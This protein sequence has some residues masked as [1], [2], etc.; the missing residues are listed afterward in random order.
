MENKETRGKRK[1]LSGVVVSDKGNKTCV[2]EVERLVRHGLY[3]KTLKRAAK[4][5]AHDE[6]NEAKIGD[7]VEIM[8]TRPISKMKRW[9]LSKIVEKAI[10]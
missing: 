10:N 6:G 3:S 4:F 8:S 5:H 9:R 1:V 2:V 7:K